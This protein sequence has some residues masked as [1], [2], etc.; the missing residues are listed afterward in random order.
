MKILKLICM[1]VLV[2]TILGCSSTTVDI[3]TTKIEGE[4]EPLLSYKKWDHL[5]IFVA[6]STGC[7]KSDSF[8]LQIDKVE[9]NKVSVSIIRTRPDYCRRSPMFEEFQLTLPQELNE[10][11]LVVNNPLAKPLN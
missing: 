10:V 11:E 9:A 5:L 3:N 1:A 7:T 8:E 4:V 6:K 2:G